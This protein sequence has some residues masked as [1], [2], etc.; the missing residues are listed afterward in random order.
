MPDPQAPETFAR[1]VLDPE[2]GDDAVRALYRDLLA[3][4]A[5]LPRGYGAVRFDEEGGWVAVRRGTMEVVGNF[6]TT[7]AEVRVDATD[8]VLATDAGV[9]LAGG[10]LRLPPLAGAVVA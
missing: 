7:D 2:A 8:V 6:S 9:D 10:A 1:S 3:L 5:R 4:R